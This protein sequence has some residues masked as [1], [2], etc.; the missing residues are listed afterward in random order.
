MNRTR[1]GLVAMAVTAVVVVS[2]CSSSGESDRDLELR[3]QTQIDGLTERVS[4]LE[5]R[6]AWVEVIGRKVIQA[7]PTAFEQELVADVARLES[8]FATA[9]TNASAVAEKVASEKAAAE[10]AVAEAKTAVDAAVAAESAEDAAQAAAIEEAAAK[11]AAAR[12]AL[13]EL[14][15]KIQDALGGTASPSP[16]TS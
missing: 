4:S 13:E 1:L 10:K 9:Q 11:I 16:T 3:M 2:G 8:Q 5:S 14:K 7:D 6:M 15:Q 12:T